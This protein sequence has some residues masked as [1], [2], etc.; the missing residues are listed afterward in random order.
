[1]KSHGAREQ[2]TAPPHHRGPIGSTNR[3]A[4]QLE[5]QHRHA[6][7]RRSR[8]RRYSTASTK[9]APVSHLSSSLLLFRIR[10]RLSL[11][12]CEIGLQTKSL[13]E[14]INRDMG[15]SAGRRAAVVDG[16]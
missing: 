6:R 16:P 7:G 1:M 4:I 14:E 15:S 9:L 2:T 3:T 12:P 11:R 5:T 13:S 8:T 10:G